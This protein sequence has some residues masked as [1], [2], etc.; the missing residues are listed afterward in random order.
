MGFNY[1]EHKDKVDSIIT[2]AKLMNY[3][4]K[5]TNSNDN[6]KQAN[7]IIEFKKENKNIEVDVFTRWD[8]DNSTLFKIT[9]STFDNY[10]VFDSAD[11][12]EDFLLEELA[13]W[14]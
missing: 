9:L 8:K 6:V 4:I 3:E 10:Q 12:D 14:L 13:S 5:D 11:C 7:R 2:L 1:E